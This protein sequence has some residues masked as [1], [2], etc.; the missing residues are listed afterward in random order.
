[1]LCSSWFVVP[2]VFFAILF[3]T[4]TAF[5]MWLSHTLE[6]YP[7]FLIQNQDRDT[8]VVP[9]SFRLRSLSESAPVLSAFP[10][11]SEARSRNRHNEAIGHHAERL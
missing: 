3:V 10:D 8:G 4:F 1:M 9:R 2:A 7:M 6:G 11:N 5:T